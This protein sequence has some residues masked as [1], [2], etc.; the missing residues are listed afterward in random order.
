MDLSKLDTIRD[1]ERGADLVL[2]NPYNLS[3]ELTNDAGEKMVVRV[4]GADARAFS[5]T[6]KRM[7][8][9]TLAAVVRKEDA[10]LTEEEGVDLAVAATLGWSGLTWDGKP[11]PYSTDNAR[12]LYTERPWAREQVVAFATEIKNFEGKG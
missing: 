11:F 12:R 8:S 3:E 2:R 10:E 7:A 1:A 5:R 4:V 9:K 6:R